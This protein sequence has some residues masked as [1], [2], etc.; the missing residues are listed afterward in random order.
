MKHQLL[1]VVMLLA[2]ALASCEKLKPPSRLPLPQTAPS[3]PAE[4]A[5][6]AKQLRVGR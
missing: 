6:A 4:Q 5:S 1:T 2:L 3:L